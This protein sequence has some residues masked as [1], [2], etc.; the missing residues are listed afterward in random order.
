M[1]QIKVKDSFVDVGEASITLKYTNPMFR[2]N[3]LNN[4]FSY[5]FTLPATPTNR[6]IFNNI[7]RLDNDSDTDN[8]EAEVFFSGISF[9]QGNLSVKNPNDSSFNCFLNN[10]DLNISK[11]LSNFNIRDLQLETHRL[12]E[13]HPDPFATLADRVNFYI[14]S[15]K[16][17]QNDRFNNDDIDDNHAFPP[18]LSDLFAYNSGEQP[19]NLRFNYVMKYINAFV[20]GSYQTNHGYDTSTLEE[21]FWSTTYI[22]FIKYNYVLKELFKILDLTVVSDFIESVDM[23]QLCIF[24]ISTLDYNPTLDFNL[25]KQ[26]YELQDYLPAV[27]GLTVVNALKTIF[28]QL[29]F[30]DNNIVEIIPVKTILNTPEEDISKYSPPEYS[31]STLNANGVTFSYAKDDQ[32]LL[33]NNPTFTPKTVVVGDGKTKN[34]APDRYLFASRQNASITWPFWASLPALPT[35]LTDNPGELSTYGIYRGPLKSDE[36][37]SKVILPNGTPLSDIEGPDVDYDRLMLTFYRGKQ[38]NNLGNPYPLATPFSTEQ[39]AGSVGELSLEWDGEDGLYNTFWKDYLESVNKAKETTKLLD[40]P[41]H[42]F[43]DFATFKEPNKL[44]NSP[45]GQMRGILKEISITLKGN[46][47]SKSTCVFVSKQESNTEVS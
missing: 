20:Q 15:F 45:A 31:N 25:M 8:F 27:S 43:K 29:M 44:I 2:E 9:L 4:A 41:P 14:N 42:K 23:K 28:N 3:P 6:A 11:I 32:D 10:R 19:P 39:S 33:Y 35:N 34:E 24:N 21:V 17:I 46:T 16:Q 12:Y 38:L 36:Y 37:P 30:I 22:P 5:S 1:L 40:L 26:D 7:E 13:L 18:V 47:A